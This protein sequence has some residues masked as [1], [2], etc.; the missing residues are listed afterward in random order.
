MELFDIYDLFGTSFRQSETHCCPYMAGT[1]VL[2]VM[3][4][5]QQS[6]PQK[7]RYELGTIELVS[8]VLCIRLF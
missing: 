7:G 3:I 6:P 5:F 4:E 8:S 2:L 1:G